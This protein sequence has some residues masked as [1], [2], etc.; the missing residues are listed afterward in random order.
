M[1]IKKKKKT[2]KAFEQILKS[3]LTIIL[4]IIVYFL[5]QG[6][7]KLYYKNKEINNRY[8]E[9]KSELEKVQQKNEELNKLFYQASQQEYIEKLIRE[10]GL[11]KRPGEEVVVIEE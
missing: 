5:V 1:A 9:F 10:K 3:L 11:Y 7:I 4:L 8:T 6:N 2:D